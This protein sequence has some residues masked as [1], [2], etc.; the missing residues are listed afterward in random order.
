MKSNTG[1]AVAAVT[2]ANQ[3]LPIVLF[4]KSRWR[5]TFSADA[6]ERPP[7]ADGHVGRRL[8]ARGRRPRAAGR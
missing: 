7:A 4:T 2:L 3:R 5:S 1:T 8:D 6:R